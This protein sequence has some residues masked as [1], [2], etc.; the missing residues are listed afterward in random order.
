VRPGARRGLLQRLKA[1]GARSMPTS[2]SSMPRRRALAESAAQPGQGQGRRRD[3]NRC[4][5]DVRRRGSGDGRGPEQRVQSAQYAGASDRWQCVTKTFQ[6]GD[7]NGYSGTNDGGFR[8]SA[9]TPIIKPPPAS[10]SRSAGS[11]AA[12]CLFA[13]QQSVWNGTGQIPAGSTI[14]SPRCESRRCRTEAPRAPRVFTDARK[15]GSE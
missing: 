15:L 7:S 12:G 10:K 3:L 11:T 5:G 13:S 4:R 14:V 9:P 6:Q 1:L 8:S 2:R